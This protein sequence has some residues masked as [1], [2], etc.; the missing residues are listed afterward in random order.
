M[1]CL[2]TEF[3]AALVDITGMNDVTS[4]HHIEI[5]R[6][7]AIRRNFCHSIQKRS[8]KTNSEFFIPD[9]LQRNR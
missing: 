4:N 6:A 5:A 7:Y 9:F 1:L 3:D 8:A 2:R